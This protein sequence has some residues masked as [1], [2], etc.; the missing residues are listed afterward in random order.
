MRKIVNI[1]MMPV[2]LIT[3]FMMGSCKIDEWEEEKKQEKIDRDAYIKSL[4]DDGYTVIAED[5]IY[6]AVVT[7]GT[8]ISPTENNYV[9]IN[10]TGRRTDNII[11]ETTDASLAN[12][13]DP[14][15]YYDHY[16]FGPKKIYLGYSIAGFII[17][18]KKMKEGGRSIIIIPSE[19][20]YWRNEYIT[21][22]Y[23]TELLKVIED[24]FEF[25][26]LQVTF[27]MENEMN[28]PVL[29]KD[30]YYSEEQPLIDYADSITIDEGDTVSVRFNSY[31]ILEDTLILFD[32]N[33]KDNDPLTFKY[34]V[35]A[36]APEEYLPFTEGFLAALDTM[37]IGTE[38]KVLVPYE[39]GYEEIGYRHPLYNY[40]IVP[41]LTSLVYDI[42]VEDVIKP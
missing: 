8:G 3:G 35:T 12:D 27:Y 11:L 2:I 41:E 29:Y 16:V 21:V 36:T 24:P 30:V 1:W 4:E 25:D 40:I 6:Y 32:S 38:A 42:L 37:Y 7:E 15:Q 18:V 23:D 13:F 39:Q 9:I 22:I 19:L 20:G 33:F 28:D 26:S 14:Y 34:S 5:G 10:F 31:Y 17:G